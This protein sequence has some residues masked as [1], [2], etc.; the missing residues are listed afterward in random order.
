MKKIALYYGDVNC[1]QEVDGYQYSPLFHSLA[2]LNKKSGFSSVHLQRHRPSKLWLKTKFLDRRKL[3]LIDFVMTLIK[4]IFSKNI[5]KKQ[6][7][8]NALLNQYWLK[9]LSRHSP[10]II[11]GVHPSP[12][13]CNAAYRLCIPIFDYQ[14]GDLSA[15]DAY[16]KSLIKK[17][18]NEIPTGYLT[19]HDIFIPR[20]KKLMDKRIKIAVLPHSGISL[21]KEYGRLPNGLNRS[22]KLLASGKKGILLTLGWGMTKQWDGKTLGLPSW[23]REPDFI[24]FLNNSHTHIRPHPMTLT[25]FGIQKIENAVASQF[26]KDHTLYLDRGDETLLDSIGRAKVNICHSSGTAIEGWLLGTPTIYLRDKITHDK[27]NVC[28]GVIKFKTA[29]NARQAM[30]E[31]VKCI[32]VKNKDQQSAPHL[33]IFGEALSNLCENEVSK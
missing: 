19:W 9:I 23:T 14:H 10:D 26:G 7:F 12:W 8:K 13:I 17:P 2:L 4:T 32:D 5:L 31:I 15:D 1:G 29:Y 24:D 11:I 18:N 25:K 20:I 33:K 21:Y 22:E 27:L 3:Y 28:E 16:Y 30:D 6:A